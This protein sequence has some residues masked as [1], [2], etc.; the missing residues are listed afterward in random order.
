MSENT[1][2]A[3]NDTPSLDPD[4]ALTARSKQ[5]L[6]LAKTVP[7]E[8]QVQR[9]KAAKI[10][11]GIKKEIKEVEAQ[12]DEFAKPAFALYKKAREKAKPIL[13]PLEQAEVVLK[14]RIA[15]G[16]D[17]DNERTAKALAAAKSAGEVTAVVT[18]APA[19]LAG[20]SFRKIP[21]YRVTD[22]A[23]VPRKFLTINHA[24]IQLAL[25]EDR[26]TPIP[27]IEFYD[28]TS[29]AASTK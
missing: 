11:V 9:E 3:P 28:E 21:K 4:G 2:L 1:T 27:G 5:V 8:T 13:D 17:A 26:D 18:S 29:V 16:L 23:L 25:K 24:K 15:K 20:V 12:R 6:D 10:L 19:E 7:C 14:D 22:E